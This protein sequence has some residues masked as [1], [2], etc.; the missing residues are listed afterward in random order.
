MKKSFL[1]SLTVNIPSTSPFSCCALL[2][3]YTLNGQKLFINKLEN[4]EVNEAD[5]HFYTFKHAVLYR[6]EN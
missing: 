6:G 3:A 1:Q 2:K 4:S 5:L